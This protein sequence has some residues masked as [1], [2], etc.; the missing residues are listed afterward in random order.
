MK[1]IAS[2]KGPGNGV[3][4]KTA[5]GFRILET[6]L[7][8]GSY[9][10]NFQFT[11]SDTELIA[12]ALEDA[13]F[14]LIEVGH[15]VGLNASNCGAGQAAQTD[16]EYMA[17]AA[18][19]LKKAKFGMFCIPGIARL[20][21]IDKAAEHGM[22]FIRIG[23]DVSRMEESEPFIAR[24][25]KH[26][27]YVTANFMKSY[28]MDPKGFAEKARLSQKFGSEALYLVD[29]AGGMFPEDIE[30]YFQ[31]VRDVCDIPL[32]F[33]GHDNLGL[34][35]INTLKAIE[36]GAAL[37]D[38]SLQGFGRSAGNA[39]TELV[40]AAL[41]RR[42]VPVPIDLMKVFDA[43]EKFIKPLITTRGLDSLDIVAGYSLFHSSFMGVIKKYSDKYK[44]DPRKL[45]IGVTQETQVSAPPDLVER[46]AREI[47]KTSDEV[48]TARYRLDKY[49]GDEQNL[50]EKVARKSKK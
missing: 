41:R 1:K 7:R 27:M 34:A 21:D 5:P 26:G 6:T 13:G 42:G 48:F 29:S 35:V 33:H 4:G 24:A 38:T 2:E 43:G 44:I 8:D 45:I 46:I 10:I 15:G 12:A 31:A 9:T 11:A 14:E 47:S 39:A 17:A 19:A 37:A 18:R 16:E 28:V 20:E 49:H 23:T 3:R 30:A 36:L 50:E 25:R 40:V 32:G 22:G